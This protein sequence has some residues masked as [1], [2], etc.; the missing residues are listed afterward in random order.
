M[1]QFSLT[2]GWSGVCFF[3]ILSITGTLF[4]PFCGLLTTSRDSSFVIKLNF[5]LEW[6]S[7]DPPDWL[8]SVKREMWALSPFSL[9][10]WRYVSDDGVSDSMILH[11]PRS[12]RGT[13]RQHYSAFHND[14]PRCGKPLLSP[15]TIEWL[16]VKMYDHS[17][18][19]LAYPCRH[20]R[21]CT[22]HT[23]IFTV[24]FFI[25]IGYS[26]CIKFID[27]LFLLSFPTY[28]QALCSRYPSECTQWS[29]AGTHL[30]NGANTSALAHVHV[31]IRT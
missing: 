21:T 11:F 13:W 6:K 19:R 25:H 8:I 10:K 16:W 23:Q 14:R 5:S 24:F 27:F 30:S 9:R 29:S 3:F 22:L 15:N 17:C 26:Y 12:T 7:K 20:T 4:P 28:L 2:V 1:P 18:S 31:R